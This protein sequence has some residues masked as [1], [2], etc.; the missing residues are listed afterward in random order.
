M[1][2]YKYSL[3]NDY[4]GEVIVEDDATDTDI[5]FAILDDLDPYLVY[6]DLSETFTGVKSNG[7]SL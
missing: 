6:T 4:T 5:R 2:H 7:A 3:N 1:K